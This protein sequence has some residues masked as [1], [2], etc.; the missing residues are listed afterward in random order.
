MPTPPTTTDELLQL[1]KDGKKLVLNQNAYHNFGFW[2]AFGGQLVDDTGKCTADQGGFTEAMQYLLDLKTA[3]SDN[4]WNVFETDGSKADTLFRQGQADM[5]INGPWVLGDYSTDLGDKLGV[6]PMPAGPAGP[7]A[8]LTAPD[9]FYIN[10]NSSNQQTAVD[11]AVAITS[12]ANETIYTDMAGHVPSRGDVTIS[13]PLVQGFADASSTGYARP[14]SAWFDNYWTPFG[15]LITKVLEAQ[16]TPADGVKEACDA[17][18]K[19][20]NMQ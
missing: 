18:N 9:G 7:S 5:I 16:S 10:P 3:G 20:N 19:A 6:V 1:V 13:D 8:P 17:M 11:L 15:D 4:G 14:Q 12:Q 2:S